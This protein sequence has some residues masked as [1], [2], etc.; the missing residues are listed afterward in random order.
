M[1][2]VELPYGETHLTAELPDEQEIHILEG[3][4]QSYRPEMSEAELIRYAMEHPIGS[5]RLSELA[6]GKQNVVLIC[7]D[8]TRPVP[9]RLI[10]PEM[11][12]EIRKGSPEAQVTLLIATG[13]HRSMLD[14]E[15]ISKFGEEIVSKETIVIH[16]C[17]DEAQLVKIGTLPSGGELVIN[18]LAVEADLVCAEGFIEPH[19]FAGFSGGR[20]S[21]L[22]GIA[23]RT[24]VH[25][26]H[27]AA[28]IDDP[29]SRMGILEDNPIHRD[30]LYAAKAA[31]LAYIV[32]VVID[33]EKRVIGA[34]AG[35]SNHAHL[36][37][38]EFVK[39]LMGADAVPSDLVLTTNNGYPLDQNVYQM[40]KGI[41]TA[42]AACRDGGVII[43]AGECRDGIGGD[44]FFRTFR[45]CSD[46][47]ALLE[48]FRNT[49]P[50]ET[51]T[52]QW[53]SQIFARILEKHKVIF[54][55]GVDDAIIRDFHMIPAH[56]MAEALAIAGDL[57]KKEKYT[58]TVIP[59][60]ISVIPYVK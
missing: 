10:I 47:S 55:S 33:E 54:I 60:G 18:R 3:K 25:Y 37:G 15:L 38:T 35:D 31:K 44:S 26:N 34:F 50:E 2:L 42:E 56:T 11:L 9:S 52:D 41:C 51:I 14:S 1:M 7:S 22:P 58:I 13:C 28:F 57:L 21:I 12:R 20:K 59:Q 16:D 6:E 4:L 39:E 45:D 17:E 40:V 27:N 19:F 8:H 43:A 46:V 23:S 53:Q 48:E 49:P 5:P 36:K 24:C 29:H 32:N 30:M